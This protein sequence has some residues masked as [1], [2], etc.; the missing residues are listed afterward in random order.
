MTAALAVLSLFGAGILAGGATFLFF[1]HYWWR[2]WA[3]V[4]ENISDEL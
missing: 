3:E 2:V 1:G 4:D